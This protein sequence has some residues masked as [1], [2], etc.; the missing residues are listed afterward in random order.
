MTF[1]NRELIYRVMWSCTD[2]FGVLQKS[3]GDVA[4]LIGIGYQQM[5]LI[6]SEF[7]GM[8][9]LLKDGHKFTVVYDPNNISWGDKYVTARKKYIEKN[10]V[11]DG[12]KSP[13]SNG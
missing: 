11:I 13:K 6:Y 3:Q 12:K 2:R 7:V 1:T 5:S 8:G 4:K 10:G 9:M